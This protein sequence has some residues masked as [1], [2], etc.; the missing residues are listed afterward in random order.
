MVSLEEELVPEYVP[1]TTIV[2][3]VPSVPSV[4]TPEESYSPLSALIIT[5][6]SFLVVFSILFLV[7]FH[8]YQVGKQ[9]KNWIKGPNKKSVQSLPPMPPPRARR[10][11]SPTTRRDRDGLHEVDLTRESLA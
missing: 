9:I 4:P 6:V 10:A 1:A 2:P 8:F 3:S 7:Y 11:R 5:L